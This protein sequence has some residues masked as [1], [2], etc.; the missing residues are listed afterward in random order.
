MVYV[1][2]MPTRELPALRL[3][4]AG[5]ILGIGCAMTM[6]PRAGRCVSLQK[7]VPVMAALA[8]GSLTCGV[9]CTAGALSAE[10]SVA[11]ARMEVE[12]QRRNTT[13]KSRADMVRIVY[14]RDPLCSGKRAENG[15]KLGFVRCANESSACTA[16]WW[17][18]GCGGA[19]CACAFARAE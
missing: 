12:Q 2:S 19:G 11:W 14:S 17:P 18:G 7:T 9:V 1:P 3:G 5:P 8:G 4:W 15:C 10:S 13:I 16:V 6:A